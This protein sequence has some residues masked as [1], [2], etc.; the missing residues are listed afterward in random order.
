MIL[1]AHVS[2]AVAIGQK[3]NQL[4]IFDTVEVQV[5]SSDSNVQK[6]VSDMAVSRV[7]KLDLRKPI[8]VAAPGKGDFVMQIMV[9]QIA[10]GAD[11]AYAI[12]VNYGRHAHCAFPQEPG[13]KASDCMILTGFQTIS[14]ISG[15][16]ID[17]K[18]DQYVD[19]LSGLMWPAD[20][21][22]RFIWKSTK[23]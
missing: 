8:T 20:R 17:K 12:M 2:L 15:I 7:L 23:K 22:A 13:E 16:H 19:T 11:P 18:I 21:T 1:M 4:E 14:T 5:E 6:M 9:E 3:P 10:E